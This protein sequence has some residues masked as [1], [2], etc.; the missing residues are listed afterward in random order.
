MKKLQYALKHVSILFLLSLLTS[1]LPQT[2]RAAQNKK[3]ELVYVGTYTNH[4]SKG[5]Y[6][7]EFDE[8]TGK[9]SLQGLAA[10]TESPSFLVLS[11]NQKFVY[12]VNE[13]ENF[14]GKTSGG[15]SAFSKEANSYKLD[16]LNELA[17]RGADPAHLAI[18]KTGR[19]VLV[20]NYTSGNVAVFPILKNGSLGEAATFIQ[21]KGSGVNHERQ[22]GPHA[23][24]IVMSP[25]NHFALITDLG[26]DKIFIYPFDSN[27]GLLGEPHIVNTHP[28]AGPR[29]LVFSQDGHF[30]YAINELQ[31]TIVVYAYAAKGDMKELQTI[32]SLPKDFSGKN[33]AAEIALSSS[34]KFLYASNRGD[35]SIAVFAV[36]PAKGILRPLQFISAQGKTPRYFVIDPSGE[37]LLAANQDSG[38]IVTFRIDQKSGR[39]T[40]TGQE[41]QLS[42]PVCIRFVPQM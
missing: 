35:D 27:K 42:S 6:A 11:N 26:L 33:T 25:D 19:Y 8:T 36:D 9:L 37:F 41:V 7:Y 24:E 23:H 32:S 14:E 5:I 20:A 12:A 34:G 30:V 1:V 2:A 39:L 29:H 21:H 22:E 15:V 13:T 16:F 31:S 17:S 40:A 38:N 3:S 10:E 28:G 4:G 18:D